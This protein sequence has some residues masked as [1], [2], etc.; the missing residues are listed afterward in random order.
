MG[1]FDEMNKPNNTFSYSKLT[2]EK[3]KQIISGIDIKLTEYRPKR[4]LVLYTGEWGMN[5][6]SF[7]M[8]GLDTSCNIWYT[9]DTTHK[10]TNITVFSF[11]KKHGF[12]KGYLSNNGTIRVYN[13]TVYKFTTKR[14]KDVQSYV[15]FLNKA[16]TIKEIKKCIANPYYFA[17]KYMTIA[18]SNGKPQPF[19]TLLNEQSFNNYYKK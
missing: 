13:G 11:V 9:F 5:M 8:Q 4:G 10:K 12:I 7:A 17:T 18:D 16:E 14:L 1:I 15:E 3:L 19:T 6:F 2:K